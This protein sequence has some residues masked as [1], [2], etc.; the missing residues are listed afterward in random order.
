MKKIAIFTLSLLATLTF[1]STIVMASVQ[2]T[3]TPVFTD[4]FEVSTNIQDY[5][6]YNT[7]PGA[8]NNVASI[9]TESSEVINGSNSLKLQTASLGDSW[10]GEIFSTTTKVNLDGNNAYKVEMKVKTTGIDQLMLEV[11]TSY[12]SNQKPDLPYDF[13]LYIDEV[14][15]TLSRR[16]GW[17]PP[18]EQEVALEEYTMDENGVISLSFVFIGGGNNLPIIS[19]YSHAN[20]DNAQIILDD[21]MISEQ[22]RQYEQFENAGNI[23]DV[24]SF[25]ANAGY[26]SLAP[27]FIIDGSGSGMW[28]FTDTSEPFAV[29]IG[30]TNASFSTV[31]G[32][33]HHLSFDIK[34]DADADN[35]EI[36]KNGDGWQNLAID[37]TTGTGS[38]S[39]TNISVT[40]ETTHYHVEADFLGASNDSFALFANGTLN[41]AAYIILD[42]FYITVEDDK[43]HMIPVLNN[44]FE[45]GTSTT[46]ITYQTDQLA[47]S[48]TSIDYSGTTLT[49]TVDY[50]VSDY[51]ISFNTAFLQTLPVGTHWV[52]VYYGTDFVDISIDVTFSDFG[53]LYD[54]VM[55]SSTTFTKNIDNI[56]LLTTLNQTYGSHERLFYTGTTQYIN[57]EI[58]SDIALDAGEVITPDMRYGYLLYNDANNYLD[59]FINPNERLLV[60]NTCI[61]STLASDLMIY[62][63]PVGTDFTISQ[64][65]EVEKSGA[66]FNVYVDDV[67][68]NT[69][70]I[71][72]FSSLA[73]QAALA[74]V[75]SQGVSFN[76]FL[77][78]EIIPDIA[79][80]VISLTGQDTSF[81]VGDTLPDFKTYITANDAIDGNIVITDEMINHTSLDMNKPGVYQVVFT[82]ED[83]ENNQSQ[84][85][86]NITVQAPLSPVWGN[87]Y[88]N[89]VSSNRM[90]E[91]SDNGISIVAT[92][93]NSY[94]TNER[95][96][97][98]SVGQFTD[99]RLT[100]DMNIDSGIT[101]NNDMRFGYGLYHDQ[102]NYVEYLVNP[103][104]LELIEYK[105]VN[106]VSTE[107][108][109]YTFAPLTSFSSSHNFII[110]KI[111]DTI[112]I[113]FDGTVIYSLTETVYENLVFQTNV[114]TV[115]IAP[116]N[117]TSYTVEN[118]K[119]QAVS[120]TYQKYQDQDMTFEIN[121]KGLGIEAISVYSM[122]AIN[123]I[124]E[125]TL[126]VTDDYVITND[127][128]TINKSF[129]DLH[130]TENLNVVIKTVTGEVG[131]FVKMYESSFTEPLPVINETFEEDTDFASNQRL[132]TDLSAFITTDTNQVIS[133]N[134]SL[135]IG[136]TIAA[137]TFTPV[138]LT[139]ELDAVDL[140]SDNAYLITAKIDVTDFQRIMFEYRTGWDTNQNP[141]LL[142]ELALEVDASTSSVVRNHSG[143]LDPVTLNQA[144]EY[145][146]MDNNILSVSFVVLGADKP[147]LIEL[148]GQTN[149]NVNATLIVDDFTVQEVPRMTIDFEN[150]Q[151]NFW[152]ETAIWFN[153]ASLT[154]A[155]DEVIAGTT[156]I[157]TSFTDNIDG[158]NVVLGGIDMF[159]IP[160]L[161]N[162]RLFLDF[163]ISLDNIDEFVLT[164]TN[165]TDYKEL[166]IGAANDTYNSTFENVVLT[167]HG[168]FIH[169]SLELATNEENYEL[170]F[171]GGSPLGTEGTIVFDNFQFCYPDDTAHITRITEQDYDKSNQENRKYD[172]DILAADYT[173]AQ[174]GDVALVLDVDYIVSDYHL[175]LT[176]TFLDKLPIGE[177]EIV[178]TTVHGEKVIKLFISD[179]RPVV[180][181]DTSYT[182]SYK[183]N[184]D[185]TLSL[186]GE[187][188]SSIK[189]GN[190]TLVE[191]QDY[192][193]T[194]T[195]FYLCGTYL[196]TL[197]EGN[198][199]FTFTT[200]KGSTEITIEFVEGNEVLPTID[201]SF[202]QNNKTDLTINTN[203]P[204]TMIVD[205]RI[206][207]SV[208]D[209]SNYAV[210]DNELTLTQSYLETL[211]IGDNTITIN[212]EDAGF[213]FVINVIELELTCLVGQEVI[214]NE[215]VEITCPTGETLNGNDCE[216]IVC[217]DNETLE[218]NDCI[219]VED[220]S[221][222][223][224]ITIIAVSGVVVLAGGAFIFKRF[225]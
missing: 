101:L 192:V 72:S 43:P 209:A 20:A 19:L 188:L 6:N 133:G 71:D 55:T 91:I 61:D 134:K 166:V 116:V 98:N 194:D 95:A 196:S 105:V 5:E 128:V 47:S 114:S 178:V 162:N 204:A 208:I 15:K 142:Y 126:T 140:S 85:N 125:L 65:L 14:N 7:Y 28:E 76:N 225:I 99:L 132:F 147:A 79:G 193:I 80:P 207:D 167:Y 102:S 158:G 170:V 81:T 113:S 173:S 52:R 139:T 206:N 8:Y 191:N 157:M 16:V 49:E 96:F 150:I 48:L 112:S 10:T 17:Y 205:L 63:Y 201:Y 35:F 68:V 220:E 60:Y 210:I 3:R 121:S 123:N 182:I 214:N 107:T 198:H 175:E 136:T 183:Q 195:S 36:S 224:V 70:T 103:N 217:Q 138:L 223:T 115:K 74:G 221:N 44:N 12:N 110:E 67:K 54:D 26:I 141:D 9:T 189:N 45:N 62:E 86:I 31:P 46:P 1:V 93:N 218:G 37:L 216:A 168:N 149:D 197:T 18:S 148:K 56:L 179:S 145:Y 202:D 22:P 180:S 156:S 84:A 58:I 23:W 165:S 151:G 53:N 30:G 57:L 41:E 34:G 135:I 73:F 29:G 88:D 24:T 200:E 77:S 184:H 130:L 129:L 90:Y 106:N 127:Q 92:M 176:N 163:D 11:R 64:K 186:K 2:E 117:Y 89:N 146:S 143:W 119:P 174:T 164:A 159:N 100:S 33:V 111:A 109:V 25:W 215:C 94:G 124:K 27:G 38:G 153:S 185:L 161:P 97:Y 51:S 122:D 42:N 187:D 50:T 181:G 137:N 13:G 131:T 59:V 78:Q 190:V 212:L 32:K 82:V 83:E 108:V 40:D 152:D 144:T 39:F 75:K 118:L 219:V 171:Y 66:D 154:N 172:T 199:T 21:I 4:S 160:T 222:A 104:T 177:N 213:T 87:S 211:S 169:V 155:E 69:I 203:I 120:E